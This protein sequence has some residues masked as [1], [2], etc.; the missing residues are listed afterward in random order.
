MTRIDGNT[1]LLDDPAMRAIGF[2]DHREGYWYWCRG[3]MPGVTLNFTINKETGDYS[4]L[5][6]DEMFGQPYFYGATT[7]EEKIVTAVDAMLADLNAHGLTLAVDH[8]LY[9]GANAS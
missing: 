1:P 5:V 9:G 4:E 3:I 6:M 7:F 8:S 2:T